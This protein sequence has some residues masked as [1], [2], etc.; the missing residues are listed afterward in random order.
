MISKE[1]IDLFWS[2]V[3]IKNKNEC[4]EWKAGKSGYG[5]FCVGNGKNIGAHRVSWMIAH[6]REIPKG[7][8]ICHHCDN[9]VCVNP[10]HLFLGTPR[11]NILDYS[12]KGFKRIRKPGYGVGEK[13]NFSKLTWLKIEKIRELYATGNYSQKQLGKMFETDKTNISLIVRNKAW[14]KY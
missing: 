13:N 6:K 2:K 7:F 9:P 8:L 4:W 14:I 1:K 11:D 3:N 5:E 10:E 12:Q